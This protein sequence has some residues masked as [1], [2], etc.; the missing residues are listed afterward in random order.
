MNQYGYPR[1]VFSERLPTGIVVHF[2]EDF[3]SGVSVFFSATFL[4]EQ[5]AAQS[6]RILSEDEDPG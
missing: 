3:D 6:N 4:Y 1:M 5:R 2:E